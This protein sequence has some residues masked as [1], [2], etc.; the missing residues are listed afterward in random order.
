MQ[1]IFTAH[2]VEDFLSY[3][4]FDSAHHRF[5]VGSFHRCRGGLAD[6]FLREKK[7]AKETRTC[8]VLTAVTAIPA[9]PVIARRLYNVRFARDL[10]D[11]AV[12]SIL[13]YFRY[14]I[15]ERP[16]TVNFGIVP[17]LLF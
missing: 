3:A 4:W 10:N 15:C 17:K 9:P 14:Y 8:G 5:G 13:Q 12:T 7:S 11:F 6:F 1:S 16:H 2:R